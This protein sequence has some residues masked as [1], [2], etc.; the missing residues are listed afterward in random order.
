MSE[1]DWTP[2]LREI[3]ALRLELRALTCA[4][5]ATSD[6]HDAQGKGA[7]MAK[8]FAAQGAADRM[9]AGSKHEAAR[10]GG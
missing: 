2:L 9:T 1:L 10:S 8:A 4:T 5:I 3:A 6:Y 7:E